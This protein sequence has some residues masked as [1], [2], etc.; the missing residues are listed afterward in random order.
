MTVLFWL[1]FF[2]VI[3]TYIGYPLLIAMVAGLRSPTIGH[4]PDEWPGVSIVVPFCNESARVE[5][6]FQTIKALDYLGP[7]QVIFVSDGTEDDTAQAVLDAR[8]HGVDSIVLETRQGKPAAL[9]AALP[10]IKHELV[11]YTD[12]RQKLGPECLKKLVTAM[13]QEGVGAVSGE[14]V[15]LD[16]KDQANIGLYWRYEKFIRKA[17]SRFSSVPGVTGALYLIKREHVRPLPNDALLDD[18][19]MPL[20]VLR[21]GERVVLESGALV[22]DYPA[23]DVAKEKSRKVRTLAGN[24]QAFFR[25]PWLFIPGRNPIFWQFISHKIARLL[26][27]YALIILFIVPLTDFHG[28]VVLFW[29]LQLG[30]YFLVLG[31]KKGWP[32]CAGTLG[33]VARLFFELNMAA[34]QGAYQ[35]FSG[36]IDARWERT[37]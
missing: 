11:L 3:Y 29:L 36:Q 12:A 23:S 17:E 33:S 13:Q 34:L 8:Y 25:H 20:T 27:P 2:V 15:L 28:T 26:V 14:L 5:G 6:K 24:F 18:F 7:V 1:A 31:N 37:A 19:E 10:E 35:Y 30:F 9:N 16:D 32:L 22:F 21:A 4:E